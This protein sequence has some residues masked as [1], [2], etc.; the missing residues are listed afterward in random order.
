MKQQLKWVVTKLIAERSESRM[1]DGTPP[2]FGPSCCSRFP[3]QREEKMAA[4]SRRWA[5]RRVVLLSEEDEEGGD[6]TQAKVELTCV[7]R[8][9]WV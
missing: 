7:G 9:V 6:C 5:G 8:G 3:P 2:P 1:S 4:G